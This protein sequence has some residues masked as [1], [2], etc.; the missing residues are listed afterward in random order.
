[1]LQEAIFT[2]ETPRASQHQASS[3]NDWLRCKVERARVFMRAG[4]GIPNEEVEAEFAA[5]C[6][7]AISETGQV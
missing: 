6:K 3:Y 5:R 1:M 2:K 7:R 4:Q